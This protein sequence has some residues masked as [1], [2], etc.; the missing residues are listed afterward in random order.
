LCKGLRRKH[1]GR[2]NRDGRTRAKALRQER[3]G[4]PRNFR[5]ISM[6]RAIE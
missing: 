6:A 1:P 2:D 4:I 3:L 5:E